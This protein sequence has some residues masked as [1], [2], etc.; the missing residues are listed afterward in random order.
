MVPHSV[1]RIFVTF[2][3]ILSHALLAAQVITFPPFPIVTLGAKGFSP[4]ASA[5]SGLVVSYAS[6]NPSVATVSAQGIVDVRRA[7]ATVITASQAGDGT[8]PAAVPVARTLWVKGPPASVLRTWGY[9]DSGQIGDGTKNVDRSTPYAVP[10]LD[11]I[12]AVS[13]GCYFTLALKADGTVMAWGLNDSGVLGDGTTID[14]L[15]PVPVAGLSG[16]I[17]I[18][19]GH[20]HSLALKPDGTVM[21]WGWNASGEL[22]VGDTLP[23]LMPQVVTGLNGVIAIEAGENCSYALKSDGSVVAWG[24]NANGRLG[25]GTVIRQ[26]VPK[27]I[28]ALKNIVS[29]SAGEGH[30]MA[31][32]VDGKVLTWGRN[33]MGQLGDATQDDK[34]SPLI[35]YGLSDVVE[36]AAGYY[37]SFAMKVD[38]NVVA[39]GDNRFS[40]LT[41]GGGKFNNP[42]PVKNLKGIAV[43][44]LGLLGND[45]DSSVVTMALKTDGTLVGWG[46]NSHSQLGDG[47]TT[48]RSTAP[49]STASGLNMIGEISGNLAHFVT[50]GTYYQNIDFPA[51]T[52]EI[53]TP[54][55]LPAW[56]SSGMDVS[57]ASDNPLVATVVDGK[58]H[59]VGVGTA[60]ITASQAGGG[61]YLPAATVEQTLTVTKVQVKVTAQAKTKV[62]GEADPALTYTATGLLN[63]DGVT[64][65]LA[66][67]P[68][69]AVG[70]YAITVGTLAVGENYQ[71]V[72]AGA[73]L[74][75]SAKI[76]AVTAQPKTK[77]YGDLDPALTWVAVGLVGSD[78]LGGALSRSA[79]DSVGTYPI[80]IGTLAGSNYTVSF[81]GSALSV[82][83]RPVTVRADSLVKKYGA[84]DPP[85]TWKV[86]G[87]LGADVLSGALS[88]TAGESIGRYAIGQG[89]LAASANYTIASFVGAVLSIA[90]KS[91]TVTVRST[92]KVYGDLDPVLSYATEGL[93]GTD[94]LSGTLSRSP[95]ESV[96][97]YSIGLG[98]LSHPEYALTFVSGTLS[99]TP[100]PAT[101]TVHSASKVYGDL[102]PALT[103]S[104]EGLVGTDGLAGT[105]GRAAGESVG[106][107]AIGPGSLAHP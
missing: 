102:D 7:G 22:G 39:W 61:I 38:G 88:R 69:E 28:P 55:F 1:I 72:F 11:S 74:E 52:V 92:L 78:T 49:L 40:A 16:V 65:T 46:G 68:G 34:S 73:N 14:R 99:I 90:P 77:V 5:S 48:P 75:I 58:I 13:A 50:L 91:V 100:R 8:T 60:K 54:D 45:R 44:Q 105:P 89:S 23:H 56:A 3:L 35:V 84:S 24:S 85:L 30:A 4:G 64:G 82:S 59:V 26:L 104:A 57:Y 53:G 93:V 6:S 107:Y 32:R 29:L 106:T 12:M 41:T 79:G 96:G 2:L 98:S 27:S 51:T 37:N 87:L 97:V 43:R 63:G 31:L 25:D 36:I 70:T 67:V 17:A 15:V 103:F 81:V 9:N 94:S 10:G 66:R 101:V 86:E 71:L 20:R 80:G 76:V 19:A 95:G 33:F 18:S 83:R 42:I 21:A 62:Y 47:T